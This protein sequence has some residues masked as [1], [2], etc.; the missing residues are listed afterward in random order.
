MKNGPTQGGIGEKHVRMLNH[1]GRHDTPVIR[2]RKQSPL[3]AQRRRIP[4]ASS[5]IQQKDDTVGT[6]L[7]NPSDSPN[8]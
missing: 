5:I 1:S 6:L 7:I 3:K 2:A 8:N 4:P